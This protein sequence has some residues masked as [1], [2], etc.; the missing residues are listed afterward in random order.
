MSPLPGDYKWLYPIIDVTPPAVN[1]QLSLVGIP[2]G[3]AELVEGGWHASAHPM[4]SAGSVTQIFPLKRDQVRLAFPSFGLSLEAAGGR[5][6][7]H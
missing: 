6:E 5:A 3:A 7:G 4:E 2:G 1:E